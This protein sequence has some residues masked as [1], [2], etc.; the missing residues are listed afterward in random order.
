M[1]YIRCEYLI[2]R[3]EGQMKPKRIILI[4]HGESEANVN[5]RLFAS[6][7]DYIIELTER[8]RRQAREAG[9]E[10]KELVKNETLYFYVSPFWRTRTTFEEVAKAFPREQFR[11]SEEPRLREQ[12]WGYLR[13]QEEFERIREE[14]KSYGIFYYRIPGG[15]AATDVYD[16]M[17]DLLGSLH[18]DFSRDN[19]PENCVLV[20]HGLT[21]RLFIMRWF[22]LTVEDFERMCVPENG[23]MVILEKRQEGYVLATP[24]KLL[25]KTEGYARPI[26]LDGK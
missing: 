2:K 19:F 25:E 24:L 13:S 15:E 12:E 7:P 14:R 16:R 10:L 22:H 9:V 8:G 3:E 11:Y 6:M 1:E 26:C 17:N 5:C 20:S 18:R 23:G 4:R 21:I